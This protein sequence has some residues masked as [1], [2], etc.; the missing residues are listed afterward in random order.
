ML[1]LLKFINVSK[2][3]AD[4]NLRRSIRGGNA[5]PTPKVLIEGESHPL[6]S[7][8]IKPT[9]KTKQYWDY[10]MS[11]MLLFCIWLDFINIGFYFKIHSY[12]KP[13]LLTFDCLFLIDTVIQMFTTYHVHE[14][15]FET[16]ERS[17]LKIFITHIRTV[18][19]F[20]WVANMP[21]LITLEN[22]TNWYYIKLVRIVRI[23]KVL[24][25]K[26]DIVEMLTK[27][28]EKQ[29]KLKQMKKYNLVS[30]FFAILSMFHILT[31]IKLLLDIRYGGV[32][33]DPNV[34]PSTFDLF[35]VYVNSLYYI[36]VTLTTCGYGDI[37]PHDQNSRLMAIFLELLGVAMFPFMLS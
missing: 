32:M 20:D 26:N 6:P 35:S 29:K 23:K 10:F 19:I 31:C 12:N 5:A 33:I 24:Q 8:I 9:A 30:F 4:K 14:G 25:M 34:T 18:M 21:G 15:A 36:I 17:I 37:L 22:N 7:Y 1:A 28:V 13:V 3:S 27:N 2:T 16:Y 11:L